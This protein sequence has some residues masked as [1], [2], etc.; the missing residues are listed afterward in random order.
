VVNPLGAKAQI[1][2][3]LVMGLSGALREQITIKGS[4]AEQSTYSDY[5]IMRMPEVP[6]I[7]VILVESG[8]PPTGTGEVGVPGAAPV[9][10]NAIFA[11]TGKRIRSLPLFFTAPELDPLA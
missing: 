4:K 8:A 3:G 10:A 6:A 1:E 2:G 11:A 9:V 7:E 5:L